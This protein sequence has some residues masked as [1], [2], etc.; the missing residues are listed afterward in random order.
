MTLFE[1]GN[2]CS[3]GSRYDDGD[4]AAQPQDQDKAPVVRFGTAAQSTV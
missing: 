3:V 4:G 2:T 1:I